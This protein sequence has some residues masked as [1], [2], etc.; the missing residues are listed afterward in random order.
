MTIQTL[1]KQ[2]QNSGLVIIPRKEYEDLLDLKKAVSTFKPTKAE[3]RIIARGER[4]FIQGKFKPW[5]E[6]KN[7]LERYHRKRRS[8][9]A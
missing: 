6:V 5:N 8:K 2:A 9:T 3:L 1:I 7:D 4:E